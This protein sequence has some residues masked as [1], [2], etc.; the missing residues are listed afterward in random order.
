MSYV[1]GIARSVPDDARAKARR[2]FCARVHA[3]V[4]RREWHVTGTALAAVAVAVVVAMVVVAVA[5]VIH[6]ATVVNG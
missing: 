1:T 4:A 2:T 3:C 5:V 6:N